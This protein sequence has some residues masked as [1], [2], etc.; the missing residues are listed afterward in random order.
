MDSPLT[1][2]SSAAAEDQRKRDI[3]EAES[4]LRGGALSPEKTYALAERLK[5]ANEFGYA[6]KL[7]G[8]IRS[9]GD[10]LG[11]SKSPIKVGQRHALCTYKDPD[12]QAAD[13]FKRALEILDEVDTL[14]LTEQDLDEIWAAI[15][16]SNAGTGPGQPRRSRTLKRAVA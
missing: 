3:A 7:F 8:Q 16:H 13:R 15:R 6:R 11:L 10:Y 12:L 14:K 1:P 2:T 4:A 5:N 9:K